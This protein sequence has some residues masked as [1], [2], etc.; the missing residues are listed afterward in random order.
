MQ[1][2]KER[3]RQRLLENRQAIPSEEYEVKN[4]A[5]AKSFKEYI[6]W[7]NVKAVHV[8]K[9]VSV[10]KEPDTLEITEEIKR[11]YSEITIDYASLDKDAPLPDKKYDLI[12]VP[13]MGFDK[14]NYRLGLGGGW[15]DRFLAAQPQAL[16]IGLAFQNGFVKNSLPRE[17]HDI[18][19]DKVIT[20]V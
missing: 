18:P 11:A 20:E 4:K 2:S 1:A 3:L 7:R 8:Y 9:S 19:L 5:I 14:D 15:Y 10:W 13:V 17:P 16:K 6:D 12:I